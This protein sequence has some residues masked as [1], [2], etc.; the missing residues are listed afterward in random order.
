[1]CVHRETHEFMIPKE[2]DVQKGAATGGGFG[3][4]GKSGN[5]ALTR[6]LVPVHLQVPAFPKRRAA[7]RSLGPANDSAAGGGPILAHWVLLQRLQ[8]L[9]VGCSAL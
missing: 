3:M 5:G 2:L 6:R 1:M 7:W 9:C 4:S 8:P